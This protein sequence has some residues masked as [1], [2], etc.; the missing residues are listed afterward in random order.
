MVNDGRE[1]IVAARETVADLLSR[2][3]G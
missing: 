1:R 2:E 3:R